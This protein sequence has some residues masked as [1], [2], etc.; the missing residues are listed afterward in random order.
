[1][2]VTLPDYFYFFK[3]TFEVFTCYVIIICNKM[4]QEQRANKLN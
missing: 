3:N 1:M 2:A 4:L